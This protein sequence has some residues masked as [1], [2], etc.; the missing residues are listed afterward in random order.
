MLK[1]RNMKDLEKKTNT[2]LLRL[3]K[4]LND[5][6]ETVKLEVVRVYDYWKTVEDTYRT[7]DNEIKKRGI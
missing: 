3:K 7:V 5:E 6:F 1:Y 2:D 4:E